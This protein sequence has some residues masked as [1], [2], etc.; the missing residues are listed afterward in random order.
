MKN[1]IKS[2]TDIIVNFMKSETENILPSFVEY[3][4]AD[5]LNKIVER[6]INLPV[7]LNEI[8]NFFFISRSFSHLV[9]YSASQSVNQPVS[10]VFQVADLSCQVGH[11]CCD[12]PPVLYR[13]K[14]KKNHKSFYPFFV[15]LFSFQS[16]LSA[17]LFFSHS[18]SF[19]F[20][21]HPSLFLF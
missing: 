20:L 11:F 18:S 13:K 16:S 15:C 4:L 6:K 21:P 7:K 9:I 8:P 17:S 19:L 14:R 2:V 12:V 10:Y 5:L 1:M 3:R